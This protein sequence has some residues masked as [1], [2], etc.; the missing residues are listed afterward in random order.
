VQVRVLPPAPMFKLT[1]IARE[2]PAQV[3]LLFR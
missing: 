2:V 3:Y 1:R